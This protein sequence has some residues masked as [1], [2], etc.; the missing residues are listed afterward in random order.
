MTEL[1]STLFQVRRRMEL[2]HSLRAWFYSFLMFL[3]LL[4]QFRQPTFVDIG[5]YIP[6][7]YFFIPVF[8]GSV[9]LS[10]FFSQKQERFQT[11]LTALLISDVV[12]IHGHMMV[13]GLFPSYYTIPLLMTLVLMGLL[14]GRYG[15]LRL[16]AFSFCLFTAVSLLSA[17][18][19]HQILFLSL[20]IN[21]A[22]F[23]LTAW[24]SGYFSEQLISIGREVT[25]A[26]RH[27]KDLR[28]INQLIIENV[29][30]GLM[31]FDRYGEIILANHAAQRILHEDNLSGEN[32]FKKIPM[33][34]EHVATLAHTKTS[35]IG[36]VDKFDITYINYRD[37]RLI[38][39]CHLSSVTNGPEEFG[40]IVIFQDLTEIKRLERAMQMSE[41]MAAVGQLAAGI[42]HEIRNPLAGISGS[43]QLLRA[44]TH[45]EGSEEHR[46]MNIALKEIDR[47][48]RLITDFLDFVKPPQPAE[49]TVDLNKIIKEVV[50]VTEKNQLLKHVKEIQFDLNLGGI[51]KILAHRDQ[52]RQVFYNL[53]INA[54]HAVEKVSSPSIVLQSYLKNGSVYVIVKDNGVGISEPHRKRL[55]EPFFTTKPKGTGLGLATVHKILEGYGARIFVE[56]E[57]GKG[58]E[59][60][61]EFTQLDTGRMEKRA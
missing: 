8:L 52:I 3:L 39:G 31:T 38:L 29:T 24:L 40:Y 13:V 48:N 54:C 6:T 44:T 14:H 41:K 17:V 11:Y 4:L 1:L 36:S 22:G 51:P 5:F 25:E 55:F 27:V 43:L 34:K 50:D 10:L 58:T 16:A 21:G 49:E 61:L 47:L 60:I 57:L 19:I 59:F 32:I 37:D 45:G 33:I 15:A 18:E 42:A 56:S 9:I 7:Y 23:F 26:R 2:V 53:I 28:D 20:L 30:S 12:L 35:D 46:L